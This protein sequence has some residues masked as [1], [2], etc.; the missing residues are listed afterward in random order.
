MFNV[1][2]LF[3]QRHVRIKISINDRMLG[4]D[5]L[6]QTGNRFEIIRIKIENPASVSSASTT[7]DLI[8]VELP[9]ETRCITVS[10]AFCIQIRNISR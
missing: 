2:F 8:S 7:S 6:F 3:I 5:D 9:Y 1:K 10:G 4:V